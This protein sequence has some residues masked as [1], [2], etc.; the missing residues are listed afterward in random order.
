MKTEGIFV[1]DFMASVVITRLSK[2]WFIKHGCPG[3]MST[4]IVKI[5]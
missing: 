2:K 5:F 4:E 1:P 3:T